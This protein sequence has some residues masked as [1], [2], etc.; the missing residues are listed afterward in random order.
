MASSASNAKL[1][2]LRGRIA[3]SPTTLDLALL[4]LEE[5]HGNKLVGLARG[6][7]SE[8]GFTERACFY[9]ASCNCMAF[10]NQF[11]DL[12]LHSIAVDKL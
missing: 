10:R 2:Q 12:K 11:L 1:T 7:L 3:R 6:S 5:F 9:V 4:N 8:G